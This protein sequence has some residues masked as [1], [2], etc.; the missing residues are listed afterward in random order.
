[1]RIL[2]LITKA[3]HG[4]A[5]THL[6][7]LARAA[8][9]RAEVMV[10]TGEEGFLCDEFKAI[11][12]DYVVLKH[13][14]HAP[15]FRHDSAALVELT[16]LLHRYRPDLIHAHS[17]KA[18]LLGRM[19]SAIARVPSIY[20][21]H[22]F[23]FAD[24]IPFSRKMMAWA[25]KWVGARAGSYTIAVSEAECRLARRY[26]V[27]RPG[28]TVVIYNG[29]EESAYR[30]APE[31]DPPVI[32][33]VARFSFPK[34]QE[35]LIRAFSRISGDAR[36]WLIGDGPTLSSA[37]LAARNCIARDRIVFWG[38]RGNVPELLAQAQI[39]ALISQHEGFGLSL[40]EAMSVGL[41][42]IATKVGGMREIVR[43]GATGLLVPPNREMALAG[44]IERL[45]GDAEERKRMG[46][47]GLA[48][49]R[50]LFGASQMIDRT[51]RVYEAALG[52]TGGTLDLACAHCAF[53]RACQRH[54]IAS[55]D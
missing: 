52:T 35:L 49:F 42:V 5:Q 30:A 38:D 12:A 17:G 43:H 1:M 39:A 29:V 10:A 24:G 6:L 27:V 11:G 36:L 13:L 20:T 18:G 9:R 41:P 21:A 28:R 54:A 32:A 16:E 3:E 4:G 47:A 45:V 7:Q 50:S 44:A 48:R 51:F 33:M 8:V 55:R 23:S 46:T 31:V 26:N 37:R 22:G 53:P 25:G 2:Y 34:R 19:A 15:N 14:K 40:I